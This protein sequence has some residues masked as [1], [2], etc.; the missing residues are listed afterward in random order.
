LKTFMTVL[1]EHQQTMAGLAACQGGITTAGAL[2]VR[3][4]QHG[5]KI[6]LCGNGGSAADCQH[7]A[8]ELVVRYE[9]QR[10]ALPAIALTTDTSILTAHTNDFNFETVF[11]RQIEALGHSDDCLI[12]VSTSG[13]SKNIVKAAETARRQGLSVIV[14]SGGDGGVLLPHA[15]VGIVVPSAVTARIQ[16]AHILIGHWWCGLIEDSLSEDI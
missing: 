7:I 12:A 8:A 16:E 4:L 15:S 9:K 2:L 11:S 5:G 3:T 13:H 14:L 10:R 6:L 1:E